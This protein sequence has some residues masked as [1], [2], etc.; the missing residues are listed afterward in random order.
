MKPD[1][2]LRV[3][4]LIVG[5]NKI[6]SHCSFSFHNFIPTLSH[7][8]F[9]LIFYLYEATAIWGMTYLML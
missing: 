2:S 7:F 9:D 1:V 4:V 8:W 5:I 6:V 3:I